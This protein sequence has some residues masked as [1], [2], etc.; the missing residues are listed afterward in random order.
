LEEV[1]LKDCLVTGTGIASAPLKTLIM[2]KCKVNCAFSIAAPNLL[3][4]RLITPCVRVPPL[5][6]LGSLV[7]GTII[8]DDSYLGDDFEHISDEDDCDETTD[9]NGAEYD[10]NE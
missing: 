10:A 8:L 5:K 6:N 9:D 3:L 2:L 4:L 1:D 7:T